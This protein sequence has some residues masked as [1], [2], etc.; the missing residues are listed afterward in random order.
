MGLGARRSTFA[1][2]GTALVAGQSG[3]GSGF[4]G[5]TGPVT[6]GSQITTANTG[7]SAYYDNG[8][9][10]TLIQSDLQV[11]NGNHF[12]SDF[13]GNGGSIAKKHFTG[14][15]SIDVNNATV[16]ACLF[17]QQVTNYLNGVHATGTNFN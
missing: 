8:L 3:L 13:I 1:A 4:G 17:D 11:I 16:T 12:I 15:I 9:G 14:S 7:Y 5:S 10:R 2:S 6:H